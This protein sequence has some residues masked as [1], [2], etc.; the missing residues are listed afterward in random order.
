MF[1]AIVRWL[2][3]DSG[4]DLIEYALLTCTLSAVGL[5][6]VVVTVL[7]MGVHYEIWQDLQQIAWVPS[8]PCGC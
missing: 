1:R 2:I 8:P 3:D 5:L 4:Q 6:V 7:S